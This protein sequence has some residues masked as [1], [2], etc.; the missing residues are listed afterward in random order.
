MSRKASGAQIALAY[1]KETTWGTTP[2]SPTMKELRA[3][4]DSLELNRGS[5]KTQELKI[6]RQLENTVL[7]GYGVSGTIDCEFGSYLDDWLENALCGTFATNVLKLGQARSQFT[8]E[9]RLLSLGASLRFKGIRANGLNLKLEPEKIAMISF[10][11]QGSTMTTDIDGLGGPSGWL[12][13]EPVTPPAIGETSFDIDTGATVPAAGDEFVVYQAGSTTTLRSDQIYTVSG[14]AAPTLSFT[15]ALDV[16]LVNNDILH[17]FKPATVVT[18]D[19]AMD[20]FS[21]TL[22]EGGSAVAIVS[23]LDLTITQGQEAMK[24]IGSAYPADIID[25]AVSVSGTLRAYV[26]NLALF[27]KFV[28][29][30]YTTLEF[31][32]T[33]S[34]DTYTW[35]LPRVKYVGGKGL[36]KQA[37]HGSLIQELPFEAVYDA[38]TELTSV[39]IT[40]S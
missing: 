21:G 29:D 32:L 28:N 16:A 18:S 3:I 9:R 1:V 19:D 20:A 26:D 39:K 8:V 17:M 24:V 23:A 12:V 15:P 31:S 10:P 4:G 30:T 22:S 6:H 27:N 37:S 25:N 35:L 14:Y 13:N 38:T 7:G 36:G 33:K 5:L 2:A 34:G 40:K 11:V